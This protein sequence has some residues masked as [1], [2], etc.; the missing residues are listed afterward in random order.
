MPC[1][2]MQ[3]SCGGRWSAQPEPYGKHVAIF[4]THVDFFAAR[5]KLANPYFPVHDKKPYTIFL[6]SLKEKRVQRIIER[7]LATEPPSS[8]PFCSSILPL[9]LLAIK[10]VM[11]RQFIP[12]TFE[13]RLKFLDKFADSSVDPQLQALSLQLA[14][15]AASVRSRCCAYKV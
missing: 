13:A 1:I 8:S 14:I 3:R 6:R 10:S 5:D 11:E 9:R 7:L 2:S 4:L 15:L 12:A